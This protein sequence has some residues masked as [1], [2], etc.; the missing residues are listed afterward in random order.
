MYTYIFVYIA[1]SKVNEVESEDDDV[2]EWDKATSSSSNS[3]TKTGTFVYDTV[4][5]N[6]KNNNISNNLSLHTN[7]IVISILSYYYV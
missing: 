3:T 4:F 7:K 6:N 5:N 2:L 1:Q